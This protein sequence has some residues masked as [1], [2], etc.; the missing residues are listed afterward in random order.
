MTTIVKYRFSRFTDDD[1]DFG[2][3]ENEFV[4]E[5]QEDTEKEKDFKKGATYKEYF[6]KALK[7]LKKDDAK[8]YLIKIAL[9]SPEVSSWSYI[10]NPRYLEETEN[11]KEDFNVITNKNER[12]IV[13]NLKE[14]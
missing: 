4:E 7:N 11:E 5:E 14:R 9:E 3:N 1:P 10:L 6:E 13:K 2:T 12:K 8:Y